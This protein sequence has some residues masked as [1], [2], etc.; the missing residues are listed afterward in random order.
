LRVIDGIRTR[1]VQVEERDARRP[2]RIGSAVDCDIRVGTGS[3]VQCELFLH[4]GRWVVK[5]ALADTP[6][7]IGGKVV[8]KGAYLHADD[9]ISLGDGDGAAVIEVGPVAA[10]A[11][12]GAAARPTAPDAI[13]ELTGPGEGAETW[14]QEDPDEMV[15]LGI[16]G[17]ANALP[18]RRRPVK[19]KSGGGAGWTVLLATLVV[20]GG[21]VAWWKFRPRAELP[22]R[23]V[24]V[25]PEAAP[26]RTTAPTTGP[27][28]QHK[29]IFDA[30]WQQRGTDAVAPKQVAATVD[31]R[32]RAEDWV[33]LER[34]VNGP[35]P[36]RAIYAIQEYRDTNPGQF[37]SE[38]SAFLE[39]ALDR[40]WWQRIKE[41]CDRQDELKGEIR[42][43][44]DA[45]AEETDEGHRKELEEDR[46][47]KE[48][49]LRWEMEVLSKQMGYHAKETPNL[50]D[51]AM[52]AHL[53]KDRDA[54]LYD[55]W[56]GRVVK[57][58]MATRGYLPWEQAR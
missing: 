9:R 12:G 18:S 41:L 8:P 42:Q 13:A 20:A 19:R 27:S 49:L 55:A 5:N 28:R 48:G 30:G 56:K 7:R 16:G 50:A 14:F 52:L 22:N 51:E 32:K 1:V 33:A 35:S 4:Q 44:S 58:V 31:P 24:V 3:P 11:A 40:T 45:I 57:S 37:E 36:A 17:A 23:T 47:A 25:K 2:V 53:R 39:D 54:A 34:A 38:L 29:N 43:I 46:T 15:P 26:T 10:A 21:G 6:I